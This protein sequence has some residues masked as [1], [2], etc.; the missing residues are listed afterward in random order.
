MGELDAGR[1]LT[2]GEDEMWIVLGLSVHD[3]PCH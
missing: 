2:C 1:P 3:L